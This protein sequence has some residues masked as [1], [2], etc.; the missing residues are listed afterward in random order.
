MISGLGLDNRD[1]V[2]ICAQNCP[3]GAMGP[4]LWMMYCYETKDDSHL[5]LRHQRQCRIAY[6][7]GVLHNDDV[8][9][10]VH[11]SFPALNGGRSRPVY[12]L[13]LSY[14]HTLYGDHIRRS[15]HRSSHRVEK[16]VRRMY[17]HPWGML[18]LPLLELI[19]DREAKN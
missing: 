9:H 4:L 17:R 8:M 10:L 19:P 3:A 14:F 16:I 2:G 11:A 7:K 1:R 18:A 13:S 12:P 15:S 5:N 6:K